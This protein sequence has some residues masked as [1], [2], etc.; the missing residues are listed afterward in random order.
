M[1]SLHRSGARIADDWS[2]LQYDPDLNFEHSLLKE[3]Y[4][5]WQ[6]LRGER[7]LPSRGDL[8]PVQVPTAMLPHMQLLDIEPGPPVRYR[9]RLIGTHITGALGRD[10]TGKY[11]DELYVDATLKSFKKGVEWIQENRRPIRC[12]GKSDFAQ[13]HFQSFEAIE[14][15]LSAGQEEDIETIW[16]VAVYS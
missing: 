3:A 13:K 12:F 7:A 14:M 5:L 9:W 4:T 11:W 16:V 2:P 10:S 15:P 1:E 6:R 8:D